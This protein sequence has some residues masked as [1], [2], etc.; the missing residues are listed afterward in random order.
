[1]KNG[2]VG[3]GGKNSE[4]ITSNSNKHSAYRFFKSASL[5][6]CFSL[7]MFSGVY[8]INIF[9]AAVTLLVFMISV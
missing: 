9:G 2:K 8:D 5:A 7:S 6:C 3:G 4:Y 1:V